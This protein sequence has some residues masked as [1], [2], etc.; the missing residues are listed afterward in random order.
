MDSCQL[1]RSI[2]TIEMVFHA[3]P[4]TR[5]LLMLRRSI[6]DLCLLRAFANCFNDPLTPHKTSSYWCLSAL[7]LIGVLRYRVRHAV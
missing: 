4:T 2:Y 7:T 1:S 5:Q 3:A 6:L